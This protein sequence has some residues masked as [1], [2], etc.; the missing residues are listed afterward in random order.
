M[1]ILFVDFLH[2]SAISAQFLFIKSERE[3][4][5]YHQKVSM[6]VTSGVANDLESQEI[7]KFQWNLWNVGNCDEST[8]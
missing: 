3:L 4:D 6:W 1:K 7:R 8:Q 2:F 5:G